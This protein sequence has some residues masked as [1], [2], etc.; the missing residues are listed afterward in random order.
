AFSDMERY[1]ATERAAMF[2]G[3]AVLDN[4]GV[5]AGVL[6][7]HLNNAALRDVVSVAD[8]L[9]ETGEVYL[10]GPDGTRRSQTRFSRGPLVDQKVASEAAQRAVAGFSGSTVGRDGDGR[11]SVSAY[12]PLD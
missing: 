6:M 3:Q 8:D 1:M 12:A 7:F 5:L 11:E 9:G 4:N 2:M 10:I